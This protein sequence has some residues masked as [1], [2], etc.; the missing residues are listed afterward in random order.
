M[1]RRTDRYDQDE[2]LNIFQAFTDLMSNAFMISMLLILL[3]VI[4]IPIKKQ[5]QPKKAPPI[6]EIQDSGA[7]RF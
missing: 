4:K 1:S 3:V 2:D 7:Y 6:I 5:E